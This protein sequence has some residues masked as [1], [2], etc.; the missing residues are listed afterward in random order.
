MQDTMSKAIDIIE[1]RI[2]RIHENINGNKQTIAR[3][4]QDIQEYQDSIDDY[5]RELIE[6]ENALGLLR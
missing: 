3:F 2:R 1:A 6:L 5:E 4:R